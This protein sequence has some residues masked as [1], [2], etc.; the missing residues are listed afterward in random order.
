M[1][2]RMSSRVLG[3]R[4][5]RSV[6]VSLWRPSEDTL[7]RRKACRWGFQLG[8]LWGAE[9]EKAEHTD[10]QNVQEEE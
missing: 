2:T 5:T 9:L 4:A 6:S 1:G 8:G 10:F 7:G 3:G